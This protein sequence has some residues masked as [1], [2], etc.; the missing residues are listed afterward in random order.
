M[1]NSFVKIFSDCGSSNVEISVPPTQILSN[2]H[3][4]VYT[5]GI[6]LNSI[7]FNSG[8][9]GAQTNHQPAIF[10]TKSIKIS[11]AIEA[12]HRS[13]EIEIDSQPQ[14]LNQFP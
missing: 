1:H 8:F 7:V 13:K 6:V 11:E 14:P 12:R 2:K 9:R 5:K 4:T 10:G 3:K